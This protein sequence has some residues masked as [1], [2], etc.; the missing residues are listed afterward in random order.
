MAESP[1]YFHIENSYTMYTDDN[2]ILNQAPANLNDI[3]IF[4]FN[5]FGTMHDN[6]D[7]IILTSTINDEIKVF[8]L[9][10]NT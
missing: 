3:Y 6:V 1:F 2:S 10:I 5:H 4:F 7:F 8:N 9:S